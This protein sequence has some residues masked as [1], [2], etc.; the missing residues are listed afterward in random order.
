MRDLS[1]PETL[2]CAAW[3]AALT[4]LLCLPRFCL[5]DARPAHVGILALVLAVCAFVLW[6]F[7][8]AWAPRNLTPL[9]RFRWDPQAWGLATGGGV[10]GALVLVVGVDPRLRPLYPEQYATSPEGWLGSLLFTLALGQ[11]FLCFAPVC[12]FYRLL[13]APAPA[14]IATALLGVFL[15]GLQLQSAPSLGPG[16]VVLIV[17]LRA[18][19]GLL[20]AWVFLRM[21]PWAVWWW[22]ALL[23]CR[24]LPGLLLE[25]A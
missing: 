15:L 8:F 12:F 9:F 3:A 5:W 4:T 13:R 6:G 21:G 17:L 14:A 25:S 20:A 2:R 18:A 22:A 7:V 10:V 11:L 23:E 19:F 24:L 1:R 16:F